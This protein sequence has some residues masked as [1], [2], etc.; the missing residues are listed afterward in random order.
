MIEDKERY[1]D[2]IDAGSANADTW[3]ADQIA[4]HRHQL[5]H[6][7]QSF[8]AGRCRNCNDK[9]DDGRAYCDT[10]WMS[11]HQLR[12]ASDKRNGKYRGG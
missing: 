6:A 5:E 10:D 8:D 12:I 4:E 1:A 11:D 9:L 2:L 7:A 3:L